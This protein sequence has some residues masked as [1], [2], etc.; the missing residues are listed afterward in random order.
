MKKVNGADKVCLV[1]NKCTISELERY[2]DELNKL[3]ESKYKEITAQK[4]K[5]ERLKI[6]MKHNDMDGSV[7]F[8]DTVFKRRPKFAFFDAEGEL[9]TWSGTGHTPTV[10]KE[11]LDAGADLEEFKIE[12]FNMDLNE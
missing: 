8:S 2:R 11:L 5:T 4:N 3:I 9:H 1:L 10:L 12:N 7:L 6:F